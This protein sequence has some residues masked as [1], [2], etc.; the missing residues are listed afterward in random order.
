VSG[1]GKRCR[2]RFFAVRQKMSRVFAHDFG[3]RRC[4]HLEAGGHAAGQSIPH[5]FTIDNVV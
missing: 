3:K 5:P 2:A 1:S 4:E